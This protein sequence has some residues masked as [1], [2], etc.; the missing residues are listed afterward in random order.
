MMSF[1]TVPKIVATQMCEPLPMAFKKV[2]D[3]HKLS[4]LPILSL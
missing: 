3:S 1:V 4:T 2:V